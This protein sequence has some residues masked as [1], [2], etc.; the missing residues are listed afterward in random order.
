MV[1]RCY[2]NI[3]MRCSHLAI[4]FAAPE[5]L[6]SFAFSFMAA[7]IATLYVAY[8]TLGGVNA[9]ILSDFHGTKIWATHGAEVRQF[10]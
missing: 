3:L 2:V 10:R 7:S 8:T 5:S 1:R 9:N 6:N 4:H